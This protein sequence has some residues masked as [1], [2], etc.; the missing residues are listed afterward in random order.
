MIK[1]LVL[2]R[3]VFLLLVLVS[4]TT[5]ATDYYVD[6]DAEDGGD[7]TTQALTGE[8]AA[9]NEISDINNAP[10][11]AGDTIMFQRGDTWNLYEDGGLVIYGYSGLP[12]ADIE[13]THYGNFND[14][15]PLFNGG[16]E[17]GSAS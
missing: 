5:M 11:N 6:A 3:G 7:G 2:L 12:E 13:F 1:G 16:K 9:W 8:H 14:P 4:S 10:F 17:Y 15:P